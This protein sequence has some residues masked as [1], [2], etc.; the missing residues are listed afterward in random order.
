MSN[1]SIDLAARWQGFA[2]SCS[3]I[4]S[5]SVSLV[6]AAAGSQVW[7]RTVPGNTTVLLLPT[8]QLP[9]GAY[10]ARAVALAHSGISSEPATAHFVI[11]DSPPVVSGVEFR[12]DRGV[13]VWHS[14][15]RCLPASASD[16][17]IRFSAMD[18]QSGIES[19]SLAAHP[20]GANAT[21]T[22]YGAI[23]ST[24]LLVLTNLDPNS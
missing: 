6:Y 4:A 11:D 1:G 24:L 21:W 20:L 15:V 8:R 13:D 19:T 17:E 18:V 12:W 3:G 14:A 23:R 10:L 22:A 5:Y 2:A 7:D 16:V 9:A